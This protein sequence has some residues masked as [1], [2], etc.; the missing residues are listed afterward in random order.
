MCVRSHDAE[1]GKTTHKDTLDKS[2]NSFDR[3]S[4]EKRQYREYRCNECGVSVYH[5]CGGSGSAI[6]DSRIR[7]LTENGGRS[8]ARAPPPIFR[9]RCPSAYTMHLKQQTHFDSG[10]D[11][12]R[13]L[14]PTS[15]DN[16]QSHTNRRP[17]LLGAHT[18]SSHTR[19][20]SERLLWSVGLSHAHAPPRHTYT[21]TRTREHARTQTHDDNA[22]DAQT[23]PAERFFA[24][25]PPLTAVRTNVSN[26]RA[27]TLAL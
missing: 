9:S 16:A 1:T 5:R 8:Y 11:H 19:H 21:Q 3:R 18:H 23:Q 14:G 22:T 15:S 25:S 12:R 17:A 4:R 13:S 26:R 27:G 10:A 2:N 20:P 24:V 6:L 7:Y